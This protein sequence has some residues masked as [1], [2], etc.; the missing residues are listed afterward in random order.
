MREDTKGVRDEI[1]FLFLHQAYADRFFP[2]TSVQQTRLRYAL[3]VPWIYEK[4]SAL[5]AKRRR[6]Q[7]I[8]KLVLDEE[9]RLTGRLLES[10]EED[11]VIG[12]RVWNQQRASAQ[13][14]TMVYWSALGAWGILRRLE[15]SSL[16]S[17][18]AVHRLLG[19]DWLRVHVRDEEG[20]PIDEAHNLFVTLPKPPDGWKNQAA[21][22]TFRLTE[23]EHDFLQ[24][25]I[26][27]TRR[28]GTTEP[29]LLAR[30]A[31]N[32][33]VARPAKNAWDWAVVSVA[34]EGDKAAL[35]RARRAA[36]MA[37]I[38]RALYSYLVEELRARRDGLPT[39]DRHRK[40]LPTMLHR[41]Q[42]AALDLDI[43]A[44]IQDTSALPGFF[45]TVLKETQGWLRDP[46]DPTKLLELYASTERRRKGNR[47]RLV[48]TPLGRQR[49]AEWDN[50]QHPLAEQLHYRWA[51]V[52][53]ILGDLEEH[54]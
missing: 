12:K 2:G 43:S 35:G 47:A 9:V 38:G 19:R 5:D 26:L 29:S 23:E 33:G 15:D 1:G 11:G 21:P 22:I 8:E 28:Q 6:Q 45:V 14:A 16:P 46:R 44:M 52:H 10:N 17:R 24:R 51:R 13:P 7:P 18:S 42:K 25:Q 34:D 39:S 41:H 37:A 27:T 54:D 4:I 50:Q 53:R 48:S 3:F 30:L 36:A 32:P 40:Y 20:I 31:E 49:R